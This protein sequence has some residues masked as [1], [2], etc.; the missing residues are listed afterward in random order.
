MT[1][2]P[3]LPLVCLMN[4]HVDCECRKLHG[5]R[6]KKKAA[7]K[8]SFTGS[9]KGSRF[10][11]HVELKWILFTSG[12]RFTAVH[13]HTHADAQKAGGCIA[14]PCSS[15]I[16]WIT[17]APQMHLQVAAESIPALTVKREA[18]FFFFPP[19]MKR[20]R[21]CIHLGSAARQKRCRRR[22]RIRLRIWLGRKDKEESEVVWWPVN[23]D[24]FLFWGGG[25]LH[26]RW[27]QN[28][29]KILKVS[30]ILA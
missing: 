15:C 29:R 13:S 10:S 19:S 5:G 3:F 28:W 9:Y 27:G 11:A 16:R 14:V 23:R 8:G 26:P 1:P 7:T 4:L 30:W 6:E 22:Q 12:M 2:R 24:G 18:S 20:G 17:V 25:A 21:R